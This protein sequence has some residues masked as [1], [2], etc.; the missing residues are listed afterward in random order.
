MESICALQFCDMDFADFEV[1]VLVPALS[2]LAF[3]YFFQ[4]GCPNTCE[5]LTSSCFSK[6]W[7]LCRMAIFVDCLDIL[8]EL[9]VLYVLAST[10][11]ARYLALDPHVCRGGTS[12]QVTLTLWRCMRCCPSRGS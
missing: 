11:Q 3:V 2:Q 12:E 9:L 5:F 1:L 10:A 6:Q 4:C 8:A 7:H